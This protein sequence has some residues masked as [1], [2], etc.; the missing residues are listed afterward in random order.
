MTFGWKLWKKHYKAVST[1]EVHIYYIFLVWIYPLEVIPFFWR[2]LLLMKN[3]L[4]SIKGEGRGGWRSLDSGNKM[5]GCNIWPMEAVHC[6]MIP[7]SRRCWVTVRRRLEAAVSRRDLSCFSYQTWPVWRWVTRCS[8]TMLTYL[9]I[10]V[11]SGGLRNTTVRQI[12][13]L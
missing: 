12:R 13:V 5:T 2:F 6:S 4:E 8:V 3:S 9:D 10:P 1:R 11:H 7:C